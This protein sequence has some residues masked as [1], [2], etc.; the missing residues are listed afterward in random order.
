M[1]PF[2]EAY[3]HSDLLGKIIFI[4]LIALSVISWIILI[5]KVI[6]T[7][8]VKRQTKKFYAAF[9]KY[10]Y[11]PLG[12]EIEKGS[13]NPYSE[14][15]AILKR[16][17]LE[18]LNKNRRF[19]Q[20]EESYLSPADLEFVE[21]HL[22]SGVTMQAKNLDRYL[23]ILSTIVALAPFVGLLGTVWGILTT[24]T[25]MQNQTGGSNQLFLGGL[26]LAL[27]TTV[28]GL[29]DAIPALIGYNYLKNQVRDF[30]V[31]MHSFSNEMLGTVELQYRKVDSH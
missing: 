22:S 7:R 23:Y 6:L 9:Q 26:S 25:E 30:E 31:D 15:Y 19:G 14:L 5:Y 10:R 21:S 20:K 2:I 28:I 17:T 27:A 1:N 24:F 29:I 16:Y 11:S 12:M 18:I 4:W 13:N 3:I 8:S